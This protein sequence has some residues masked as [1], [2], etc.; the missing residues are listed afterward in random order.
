MAVLPPSE[1]DYL[2]AR[3]VRGWGAQMMSRASRIQRTS[4]GRSGTSDAQLS[5][6]KLLITPSL[7][8]TS[9]M[10]RSPP[11]RKRRWAL[12]ACAPAVCVFAAAPEADEL[13]EAGAV[14]GCA[15]AAVAGLRKKTW[16][17]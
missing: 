5:H 11:G 2:S 17:R 15:A 9:A 6:L 14:A 16:K 10:R 12:A 4:L 8:S 7:N 1:S 13:A 3:A